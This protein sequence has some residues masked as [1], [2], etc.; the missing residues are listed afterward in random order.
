MLVIFSFFSVTTCLQ[1]VNL[2]LTVNNSRDSIV[3]VLEIANDKLCNI[4]DTAIQQTE[5]CDN[6]SKIS[7]FVI[8]V[9]PI[10]G[11]FLI[12]GIHISRIEDNHYSLDKA[13]SLGY[14]E[15]KGYPFIVC[16]RI[17]DDFHYFHWALRKTKLKKKISFSINIDNELFEDVEM[18]HY[19]NWWY[20]YYPL[21][22]V[23]KLSYHYDC[24]GNAMAIPQIG[25]ASNVLLKNTQAIE[26]KKH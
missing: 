9:L 21:M 1:A 15:Y 22:N 25:N 17:S 3:P 18:P 12:G 2:K 8:K 24:Y 5:D 23:F 16:S 6:I 11:H 26:N 10:Q 4:L 20:V 13:K 19:L 14:L 7:M